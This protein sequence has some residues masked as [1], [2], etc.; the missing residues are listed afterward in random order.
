M[1]P[2]DAENVSQVVDLWDTTG[3]IPVYGFLRSEESSYRGTSVYSL[4]PLY[5]VSWTPQ[6]GESG[7]FIPSFVSSM[8]PSQVCPLIKWQ[9]E[10][11]PRQVYTY[12]LG[13]TMEAVGGFLSG[14]TSKTKDLYNIVL[15]QAFQDL[16]DEFANEGFTMVHLR[17]QRHGLPLVPAEVI[18][19]TGCVGVRQLT[20]TQRRRVRR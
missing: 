17:T 13:L 12:A 8:L 20:G 6:Y 19:I 15:G 10:G 2:H 18:P 4:D 1:I 14:D 11:V 3:F 7:G 16:Y 9:L 5:P